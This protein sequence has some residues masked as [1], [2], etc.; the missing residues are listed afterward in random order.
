MARIADVS[1]VVIGVAAVLQP[2]IAAAMAVAALLPAVVTLP[3]L[4]GRE[5]RRVLALAGFVGIGSVLAAEVVPVSRQIPAHFLSALGL[6]TLMIA[7]GLLLVA[8]LEVSRRMTSTAEDLR[9]VVA[10][11]N[12][13]SRT[14]DPQLVGD[15][16]ARH[17]ARAV[18]ADDCALSYW[19]RPATASSRFGYFPLDR[20]ERAR[21]A[22][23]ALADYPATRRVL[24]SAAAR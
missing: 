20:R 17:I 3:F 14:M 1:L 5:V 18:G 11:S 23:Y 7:F 16:I 13:L 19:D 6:I 24:E 9:S 15:R 4:T 8:M 21:R 2:S 22:A 10:M 12:D